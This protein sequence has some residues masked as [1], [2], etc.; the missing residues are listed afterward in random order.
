MG[1]A[2]QFSIDGSDCRSKLIVHAKVLHDEVLFT[3]H[4]KAGVRPT[5]RIKAFLK[6]SRFKQTTKQIVTII[7][8]KGFGIKELNQL[9]ERAE[10]F[11]I[12]GVGQADECFNAVLKGDYRKLLELS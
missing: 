10:E 7:A 3:I 8:P 12:H 6:E 5:L 2:I 9:R 4:K 11:L 1:K